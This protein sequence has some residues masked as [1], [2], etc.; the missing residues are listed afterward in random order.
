MTSVLSTPARLTDEVFRPGGTFTVGAEEELILVDPAGRLAPDDGELLDRIT[1]AAPADAGMV[2][3]ELFAAEAEFATAVCTDAATIA[4]HL[5]TFRSAVHAAG[6]NGLAVGVHPDAPFGDAAL[7]EGSRYQ[8]IGDSLAGLLRTP[9]AAFQVHVGLP[10]AD[11]A[12][13]AYRGIRHR[14]AVLQA[15][16]SGSP[17]WHGRDSGLASARW[18]VIN[19]YPRGAIPPVVRSWEEYAALVDLVVT[20][21]EVPDYTHV[22]WDARLQ[23]RLGT[24]E[25]RVMDTQPSLASAAGLAALVQGAVRHAV[26]EPVAFDVPEAV[27]AENSFRVAR[28]GLETSIADVD[29]TLRPVRELAARMLTEARNVPRADGLDGALEGVEKLL[30]DEPAYCRQRRLHADGGMPAVL[31]DLLARTADGR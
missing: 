19:T 28:H 13:V 21:A 7:S 15:L 11:Q 3:R 1:R 8:L 26:Q 23:P 10:D 6:G 18:A 27:L 4:D 20:T 9:T 14:L 17:F 2:S 29:G 31:A 22:W 30:A 25:V 5:R 16:A 12:V 24:L